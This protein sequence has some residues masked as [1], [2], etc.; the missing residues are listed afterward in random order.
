MKETVISFEPTSK[1]TQHNSHVFC[2]IDRTNNNNNNSSNV[3]DER[4]QTECDAADL[5]KSHNRFVEFL[6]QNSNYILTVAFVLFLILSSYLL[7]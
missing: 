3:I 7:R 4:I 5:K 1:V 6:L 2:D